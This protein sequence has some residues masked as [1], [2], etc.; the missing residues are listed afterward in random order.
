MNEPSRKDWAMGLV[1]R[2][3]ERERLS[4]P[5]TLAAPGTWFESRQTH[6]LG[7]VS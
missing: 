5:F 3:V 4:P 6:F 7:E 2:P 1:G